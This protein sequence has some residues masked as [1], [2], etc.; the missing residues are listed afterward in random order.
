MCKSR[1]ELK[2]HNQNGKIIS[3]P[4]FVRMAGGTL[5]PFADEDST[6]PLSL[7]DWTRLPPGA[8]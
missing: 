4:N 2:Y 3:I 7:K 8:H 6:D 5:V 1:K